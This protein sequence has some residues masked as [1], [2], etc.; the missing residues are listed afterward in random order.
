MALTP[1]S[2]SAYPNVPNLPGVPALARLAG[3]NLPL[4]VLAF[5]DFLGLSIGP[6]QWG[7]FTLGGSPVF[8]VDSVVEVDIS[9]DVDVPTY[10]MESGA[11]QTYNK[12][13]MPVASK[14]LMTVGGNQAKRAAFTSA[15]E[16]AKLSLAPYAIITPEITYPSVTITH[17][18][19]VRSATSGVSL[20]T[21]Q[22]W[23][24]EIRVTATSALVNTGGT[25]G[26]DSS[27]VGTVQTV[28]VTSQ[29]LPPITNTGAN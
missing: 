16:T 19:F 21:A 18:E 3:A 13:Q 22:V 6:P 28:P 12:V 17:Y 20:I 7:I 8:V 15:L 5:A 11:F 1:L 25:N 9:A 2:V 29:Q 24:S 26:A 27:T 10:P 4:P 23:L 14:V